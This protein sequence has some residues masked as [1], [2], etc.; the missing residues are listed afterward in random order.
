MSERQVTVDRPDEVEPEI[1]PLPGAMLLSRVAEHIYWAGRYLERAEGTARLVKTHT[2]LFVDLPRSVGLGWAPLLAVTG[3]REAFDDGYDRVTEDD[4]VGFLLADPEQPRL[5][6][7][8][9]RAGPREPAGH[10]RPAPEAHVGGRQR[11][12]AVGAGQRRRPA[13][14]AAPG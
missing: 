5:G 2:E 8:L 6:D 9:D 13:A 1:V 14:P 12:P 11:D 7:H 10:P 4:V 3:S